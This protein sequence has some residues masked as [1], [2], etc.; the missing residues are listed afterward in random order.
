M[1]KTSP[2]DY[3]EYVCEYQVTIGNANDK[4]S[5]VPVVTAPVFD[6]LVKGLFSRW[7]AWT[8]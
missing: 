5:K 4:H 3:D 8:R 1:A 6:P 2:D 7:L